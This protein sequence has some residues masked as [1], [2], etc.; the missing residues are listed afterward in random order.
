MVGVGVVFVV[1]NLVLA[2]GPKDVRVLSNPTSR[3]VRRGTTYPVRL[4]SGCDPAVDFDGSY[5][6]PAGR[7]R[8]VSPAQP[9]SIRLVSGHRAL[10]FLASGQRLT[11]ARLGGTIRLGP[12][13]SPAP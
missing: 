10:L 13:R 5:W 4:L 3:H 11:L 2:T 12:C 6:G 8:L 9:A 7:W 1:L